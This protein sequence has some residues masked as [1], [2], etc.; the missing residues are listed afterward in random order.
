MIIVAL[1]VVPTKLEH[2]ASL[3]FE[4][5]HLGGIYT[6]TKNDKHVVLCCNNLEYDLLCDFLKEFYA[7]RKNQV[8]FANFFPL[9]PL[10]K[11][12][13]GMTVELKK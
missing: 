5:K 13:Y 3:W 8:M 10:K 4:R 6:G 9:I 1:V 2:L 12:I 7:H 11:I